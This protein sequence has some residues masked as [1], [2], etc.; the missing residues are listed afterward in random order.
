MKSLLFLL[1]ALNLICC[2]QDKSQAVINVPDSL[3]MLGIGQ[4]VPSKFEFNKLIFANSDNGYVTI[5][6]VSSKTMNEMTDIELTNFATLVIICSNSPLS[7]SIQVSIFD[8][9][10]K[11]SYGDYMGNLCRKFL[12]KR[13]FKKEEK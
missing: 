6:E 12:P 7:D 2:S 4:I 10:F 3:D 8:K 9:E 11:I 1:M 5:A 13:I